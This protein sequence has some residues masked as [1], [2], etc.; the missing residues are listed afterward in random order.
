MKPVTPLLAVDAVI[1][2]EDMDLI[3]LIKRKNPPHGWALPGGFVD[4][5]ETTH[6]AVRREVMEETNLK[7][8]IKGFVGIYSAPDRDPRGHVVSLVFYGIGSGLL[9]AKDDAVEITMFHINNLPV[10]LAFDHEK[11]IRDYV[12]LDNK[13]G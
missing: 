9:E 12:A 1:Y 10:P 7:F 3:V 11:I 6:T 5:G 4:I 8:D 2:K 13:Y